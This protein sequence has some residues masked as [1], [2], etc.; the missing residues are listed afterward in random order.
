MK[1]NIFFIVSFLLTVELFA[2]SSPTDG[3]GVQ[4]YDARVSARQN[5]RASYN[6]PPS[7]SSSRVSPRVGTGSVYRGVV[8]YRSSLGNSTNPYSGSYYSP[9]TGSLPRTV[10][11]KTAT[12]LNISNY[13]Q[14]SYKLPYISR[15]K[16]SLKSGMPEFDQYNANKIIAQTYSKSVDLRPFTEDIKD[17]EYYL[18]ERNLRTPEQVQRQRDLLS[19]K[20]RIDSQESL[21]GRS[22][23]G[24]IM[25]KE[26]KGDTKELY[27][28]VAADAEN[29]FD[30]IR[31]KQKE[32]GLEAE[33]SGRDIADVL[34]GD[35]LGIEGTT[36]LKEEDTGSREDVDFSDKKDMRMKARGVLGEFKS[37]AGYSDDKFNSYMKKAED[38]MDEGEFYRAADAYSL[39]SIFRR[40]DP[41]V[42]AG[43]SLALL[44]AGEY[45]SSSYY[46]NKALMLYPDYIAVK[47]DLVEMLGDRDV[48]ENRIVD[49]QRWMARSGAGELSF[50]LAYIYYQIEEPAWAKEELEKA[51]DVLPFKQTAKLLA[52]M[53]DADI[54][55]EN[56]EEK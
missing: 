10:Y 50:L 6:T 25:D 3:T 41:L 47:V 4:R 55:G 51:A 7:Q 9:V 56:T 43:Q 30:Q 12:G 2:A 19:K 23:L 17:F 49:I 48:L 53:V 29:V 45:M 13:P 1:I 14:T 21:P 42:Y 27:G 52:D 34:N 8:P 26:F 32:V 35:S 44:G 24:L 38:F 31:Q 46:L 20:Y 36:S 18:K 37:F 5:A 33:V 54:S 15:D 11:P 40:E 16:S 28:D 22:D 39:A